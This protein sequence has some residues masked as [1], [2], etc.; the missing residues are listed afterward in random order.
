MIERPLQIKLN[1]LTGCVADFDGICS[2]HMKCALDFLE[3][4]LPAVL[5]FY[6]GNISARNANKQAT[7]PWQNILANCLF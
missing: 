1:T 5:Q 6:K 3:L 2:E 4:I 7:Q